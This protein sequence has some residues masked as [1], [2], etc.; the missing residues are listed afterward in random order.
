MVEINNL[1]RHEAAKQIIV[2]SAG[3]EEYR[4][5]TVGLGVAEL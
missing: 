3:N 5:F 2:L 1:L 4:D